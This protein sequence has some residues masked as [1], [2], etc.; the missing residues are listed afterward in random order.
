LCNSL[1]P[2][3]GSQPSSMM[4]FC[5]F[6][7]QGLTLQPRLALN[8]DPPAFVSQVLGLQVCAT[9]SEMMTCP[10]APEQ[11]VSAPC[12]RRRGRPRT[13]GTSDYYAPSLRLIWFLYC[14]EKG[15]GI[16]KELLL[17]VHV[18]SHDRYSSRGRPRPLTSII[19]PRT[20]VNQLTKLDGSGTLV[21]MA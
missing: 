14:G 1:C 16:G 11:L 21:A 8:Y 19:I 17:L 4:A 10:Y 13:V 5:S 12:T 2:E 18:P 6:M 15:V 9:T 7:R 3:P 20:L